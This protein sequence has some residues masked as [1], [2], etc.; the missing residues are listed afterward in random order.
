MKILRLAFIYKNHETLRYVTFL[1]TKSQTLHQKQDNLHYVFLYRNSDTLRYA[2][3]HGIFEVGGGG[4]GGCF[5]IQKNAPC[6]TF[7]YPKHFPFVTFLY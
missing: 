2:I 1:Y 3:F 5:Y 4:W 7:L 6:V